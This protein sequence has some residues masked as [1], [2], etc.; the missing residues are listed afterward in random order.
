M[1]PG[2]FVFFVSFVFGIFAAPR[3]CL[4]SAHKNEL[5]LRQKGVGLLFSCQNDYNS[6]LWTNNL[7]MRIH[8]LISKQVGL[9]A[10]AVLCV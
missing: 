7:R 3:R 10:S 5:V 1:N 9:L 2:W 6:L 4:T 8:T